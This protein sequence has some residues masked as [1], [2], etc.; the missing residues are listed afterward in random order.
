MGQTVGASESGSDGVAGGKVAYCPSPEQTE[1]HLRATGTDYKPTRACNRGGAVA[2]PA[3]RAARHPDEGLTNAEACRRDKA[4][5]A[6]AKPLPDKDGRPETL[7]FRDA[8]GREGVVHVIGRVRKGW[9]INDH[10]GVL[11]C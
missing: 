6:K 9:T 2:P 8:D 10:A 3:Q 5:F 1:A 11:G 7:E 4:Q